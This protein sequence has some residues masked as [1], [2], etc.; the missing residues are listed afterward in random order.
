MKKCSDSDETLLQESNIVEE[1]N[2]ITDTPTSLT[3]IET[4]QCLE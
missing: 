1:N 4:T 3:E 2:A